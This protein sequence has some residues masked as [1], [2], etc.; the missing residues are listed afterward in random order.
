MRR[1]PGL[2]RALDGLARSIFLPPLV[3][4]GGGSGVAC[5]SI[6]LRVGP[7]HAFAV[8]KGLGWGCR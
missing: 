7:V 6:C 5:D 8:V 1:L 2:R 4:V 3:H